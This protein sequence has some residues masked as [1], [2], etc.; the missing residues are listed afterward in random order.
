[1]R[2]IPDLQQDLQYALRLVRRNPGYAIAAMLCLALGIGVNSTVFSLLDSIYF[3]TL[4][5]P[6]PDRLVAIDRNG[7]LPVFWRDYS[8]S[9]SVSA[10]RGIAATIATSTYMDVEKTNITIVAEAVSGNYADVLQV[11]PILGR[12]ISSPD[13]VAGAEPVTVIA[14]HIWETH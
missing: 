10:F 12:W 2:A 8:S 1:R 9:S 11:K 3:R 5:V 7:Q 14:E 6:Q 13:N 4:S